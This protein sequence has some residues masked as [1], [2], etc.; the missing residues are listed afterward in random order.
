MYGIV[1]RWL[2]INQ[3]YQPMPVTVTFTGYLHMGQ[4]WDLNF[5]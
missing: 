3:A 5:D 2:Q 1:I 4:C